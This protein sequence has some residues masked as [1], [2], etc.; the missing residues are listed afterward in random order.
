MDSIWRERTVKIK[1]KKG[2]L[3]TEKGKIGKPHEKQQL[4]MAVKEREA[5]SVPIEGKCKAE[6]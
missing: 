3:K 1:K 4:M 2:K 6:K 5:K